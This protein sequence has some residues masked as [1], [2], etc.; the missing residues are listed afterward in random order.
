M[1]TQIPLKFLAKKHFSVYYVDRVKAGI[2]NLD[3]RSLYAATQAVNIQEESVSV[4][5]IHSVN[6]QT[7]GRFANFP[8]PA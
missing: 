8:E 4:P 5:S 7:R 3:W 1:S 2:A 6:T